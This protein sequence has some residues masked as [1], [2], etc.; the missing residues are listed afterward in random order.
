MKHLRPTTRPQP[1]LAQSGVVGPF[2]RSV[3]AGVLFGLNPLFVFLLG[4][5]VSDGLF[6]FSNDPE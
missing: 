4:Q 3:I 5:K 2:I 6:G 1:Q